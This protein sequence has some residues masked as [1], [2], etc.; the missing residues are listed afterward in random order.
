MKRFL[1]MRGG[2]EA[3]VPSDDDLDTLES[4]AHRW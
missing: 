2:R 4:L 1:G 3:K